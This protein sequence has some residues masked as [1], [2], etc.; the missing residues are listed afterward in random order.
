MRAQTNPARTGPGW[1][2]ALPAAAAAIGAAALGALSATSA[3][4]G[5]GFLVLLGFCA[6]ALPTHRTLAGRVVYTVPAFSTLAFVVWL[7]P[8]RVPHE[9]LI[10]AALG[11]AL[12]WAV[13]RAVVGGRAS[14][15]LPRVDGVDVV[16]VLGTAAVAAK[17][18]SHFV[19]ASSP[20]KAIDVWAT[21]WDN[22]SHSFIELSMRHTGL[23]VRYLPLSFDGTAWAQ[24]TYPAA[25]HA[26][27]ETLLTFYLGHAQVPAE[28]ELFAFVRITGLL[29]VVGAVLAAS[30]V[31]TLPGV[32]RNPF[33]AAVG[34]GIAGSVMSAGPGA[35]GMNDAHYN[36]PFSL[37]LVMAGVSVAV[38]ASRVWDLRRVSVLVAVVVLGAGGWLP[39]GAL[40]AGVALA[41]ALPL[42][43]R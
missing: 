29:G 31:A 39:L 13:T 6:L 12:G 28:Q 7:I 2:L 32:R 43:R 35:F 24:S 25:Y 26:T 14:Q 19:L 8:A 18:L 34:A 36:Y 9:D 33:G 5:V 27:A 17:S 30:A 4:S 20:Q 1:S 21:M 3:L 23:L 42:D 37:A 22:S 10:A 38:G 11:G 40:A 41:V 16:A 15:L